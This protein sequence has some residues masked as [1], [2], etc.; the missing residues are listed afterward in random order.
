MKKK[1]KEKNTNQN[2]SI[3]ENQR[4]TTNQSLLMTL[5]QKWTNATAQV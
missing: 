1:T 3:K 2:K 5:I 4:P